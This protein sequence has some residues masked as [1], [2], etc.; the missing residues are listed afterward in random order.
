MAADA[1]AAVRVTTS[2][3]VKAEATTTANA[4][5][6]EAEEQPAPEKQP[7]KSRKASAST[8][9]SAPG[10]VKLH[11]STTGEA[12]HVKAQ[13]TSCLQMSWR[14]FRKAL[15]QQELFVGNW[16]N[17]QPTLHPCGKCKTGLRGKTQRLP[18]PH[19]AGASLGRSACQVSVLHAGPVRKR[20]QRTAYNEKGEE[21]TEMVSEDEEPEKSAATADKQVSSICIGH[22]A[23]LLEEAGIGQVCTAYIC[24]TMMVMPYRLLSFVQLPL[25]SCIAMPCLCA[26]QSAGRRLQHTRIPGNYLPQ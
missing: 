4:E 7:K 13:A 17:Q 6:A 8:K 26:C 14:L 19:M 20:V 21:V 9:R 3:P 23:L 11:N 24:R 16:F 1:D 25:R 5:A 18:H 15:L 22:T 10:T 2:E 12:S